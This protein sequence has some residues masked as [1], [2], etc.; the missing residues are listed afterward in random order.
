VPLLLFEASQERRAEKEAQRTR[1]SAAP[2]SST[3]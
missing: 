1:T 3:R 2:S